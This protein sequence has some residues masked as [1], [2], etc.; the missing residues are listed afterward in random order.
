M[1]TQKAISWPWPWSS[2]VV[3]RIGCFCTLTPLPHVHRHS[4]VIVIISIV[5]AVNIKPIRGSTAIWLQFFIAIWLRRLFSPG[6]TFPLAS[7]HLSFSSAQLRAVLWTW[8]GVV[9]PGAPAKVKSE[10]RRPNR[11]R[12][13]PRAAKRPLQLEC[14]LK[15]SRPPLWPQLNQSGFVRWKKTSSKSFEDVIALDI[16]NLGPLELVK[17]MRP[18]NYC[19][20]KR[21]R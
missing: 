2:S 19:H 21:E 11:R 20:H 9:R 15:D 4:F 18:W 16:W 14:R 3:S 7:L 10:T 1:W 12:R 17:P 8:R 6:A 5:V 13:L